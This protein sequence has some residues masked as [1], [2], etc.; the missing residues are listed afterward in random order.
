M[1][2]DPQHRRSCQFHVHRDQWDIFPV[3]P[4][5]GEGGRPNDLIQSDYLGFNP[6]MVCYCA[7]CHRGHPFCHPLEMGNKGDR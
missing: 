4:K 3:R 5:R 1:K 6:Y 2:P 7:N